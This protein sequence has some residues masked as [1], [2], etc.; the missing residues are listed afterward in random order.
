[1]RMLKTKM[2]AQGTQLGNAKPSSN[3]Y[4]YEFAKSQG[5]V[6]WHQLSWR[7]D[8]QP[9]QLFHEA[10]EDGRNKDEYAARLSQWAHENFAMTALH[11]TGS[12]EEGQPRKDLWSPPEGSADPYQMKG[13]PW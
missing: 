9:H 7:D 11:P 5:Q 13:I 2:S 6:Q 1:M 10:R 4:R 3:R 12:E 8:R